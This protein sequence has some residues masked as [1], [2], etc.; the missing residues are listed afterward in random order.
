MDK[1]ILSKL[2]RVGWIY[3]R[4]YSYN[5][6]RLKRRKGI[7]HI[8][9]NTFAKHKM[10]SDGHYLW[11]K[12]DYD[13]MGQFLDSVNWV[14][15]FSDCISVNDY[16]TAFGNVLSSVIAAYVPFVA[17]KKRHSVGFPLS[18]ATKRLITQKK[19]RWYK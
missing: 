17:A 2:P 1:F 16:Y 14:D 6:R 12:G 13:S 11:Q 19:A 5:Q 7:L 3:N 4:P 8:S 15:I 10:S 18:A 9:P